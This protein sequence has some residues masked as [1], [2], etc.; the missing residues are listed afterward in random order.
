MSFDFITNRV[1]DDRFSAFM[2]QAPEQITPGM[3][4]AVRIKTGAQVLPSG[5]VEFSLRAPEAQSVAVRFAASGKTVTLEKGEY[6]IWKGTLPYD[7]AFIGPKALDF[8]VDGAVVT[9]PYCP[10]YFSHDRLINYV[11]I[12]D[13]GATF[14]LMRDVPHGSVCTE[15]YWSRA[16]ED[17]QRCLVYLPADYFSTDKAYPVL[18]LQHGA[19]ENETSWIY[20]GR[21]AHIM[22]NLIADGKARP[23]II[24]MNNGMVRGKR[25][26][27]WM[28]FQGFE[29]TLIEDCI[30]FIEKKFRVL[31]GKENRAMAGLSMGS[32]QT[33]IIGLK[34]PELF[35]CLGLFSGFIT[36]PRFDSGRSVQDYRPAHLNM[37]RDRE[38][39]LR[40]YKLYYRG[41]GTADIHYKAFLDD[42]KFLEE[43]GCADY[44]NICR[45]VFEGFPHEWSVWRYMLWEFAQAIFR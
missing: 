24:V 11:D 4:D 3:F 33:S 20:C 43:A 29:D 27:N 39:F 40:E 37:L 30:P 14:C 36:T 31:P 15:F 8:V 1:F 23:F 44:P 34:H 19:G 17:W 41:I 38:T 6:G 16:F 12:P 25:D 22:D 32:M 28:G 42:D 2:P 45:R 35:S 13:P 18:Y 7:P 5:D 26:D 9:S 21:T 10:A